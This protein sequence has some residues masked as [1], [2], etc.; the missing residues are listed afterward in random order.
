M[1][2]SIDPEASIPVMNDDKS[3][4]K[5]KERKMVNFH[6]G[7]IQIVRDNFFALFRPLPPCDNSLNLITDFNA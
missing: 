5:T 6:F 7:A 3:E 2:Y 4:E 1:F